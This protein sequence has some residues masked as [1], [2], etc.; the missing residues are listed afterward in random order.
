M[1]GGWRGGHCRGDS[2]NNVVTVLARYHML[3][4]VL[5]L[6]LPQMPKSSMSNS[7]KVREGKSTKGT[8]AK[9]HPCAYPM[10]KQQHF[11]FNTGL[12]FSKFSPIQYKPRRAPHSDDIK[13]DIATGYRRP[14]GLTDRY[15]QRNVVNVFD[16]SL[17]VCNLRYKFVT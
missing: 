7:K 6:C 3:H 14:P 17:S 15:N 4:A 16:L 10:I 5:K 12:V 9:G 2:L 8:W 11:V 1:A 13:H